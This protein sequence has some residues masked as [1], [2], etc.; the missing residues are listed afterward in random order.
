M[1]KTHTSI[2]ISREAQQMLRLIYAFTSEPQ[3]RILD[4]LLRAEF[5]KIAE[6]KNIA[7]P[8]DVL[9]LSVPE[10]GHNPPLFEEFLESCCQIQQGAKEK[11]RVLYDR[12]AAFCAERVV[13]PVSETAFGLFLTKQGFRKIRSSDGRYRS[14]LRLKS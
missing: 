14:G 3:N 5:A 11:A 9:N 13:N 6:S 7:I 4:R 2:A 8:D 1:D 12:Y 10:S